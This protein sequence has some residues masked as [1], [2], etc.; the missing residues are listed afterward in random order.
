LPAQ[1]VYDMLDKGLIADAKTLIGLMYAR[2]KLG[3]R[4]SRRQSKKK[5]PG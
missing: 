4:K 3:I 1:K 5:K 2:E